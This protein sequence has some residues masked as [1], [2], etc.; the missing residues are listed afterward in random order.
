MTQ[1][2]YESYFGKDPP[3]AQARHEHRGIALQR[4]ASP[5]HD[6]RRTAGWTRGPIPVMRRSSSWPTAS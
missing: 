5:L 3:K 2:V 6:K 4:A 1:K